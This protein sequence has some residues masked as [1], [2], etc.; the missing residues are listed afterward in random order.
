[1]NPFDSMERFFRWLFL[2]QPLDWIPAVLFLV[3]L[4]LFLRLL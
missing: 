2:E 3:F 1:M 4:L